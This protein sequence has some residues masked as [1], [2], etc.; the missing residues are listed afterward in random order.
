MACAEPFRPRRKYAETQE[1]I[2][3]RYILAL[4]SVA[5]YL[6]GAGADAVWVERIE[7]LAWAL[8]DLNDGAVPPLLEPTRSKGGLRSSRS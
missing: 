2:R 5:D 4:E 1:R 7:E 6:E 3:D 8:E